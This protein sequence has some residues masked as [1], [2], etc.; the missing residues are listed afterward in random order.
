MGWPKPLPQAMGWFSHPTHKR[1]KKEIKIIIIK[2][3][4]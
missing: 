4:G 1:G 3:K 2:K